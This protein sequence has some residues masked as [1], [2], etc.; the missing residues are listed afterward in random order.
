MPSFT[1]VPFTASINQKGNSNTV[2]AQMQLILDQYGKEGWEY[3]R[4]DT[5]ETTVAGENGCFGIGAK[6]PYTTSFSVLV[7][8]K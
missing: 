8:K 1:V 3:Y 2:A 4:M 5:V 7:F 6:P